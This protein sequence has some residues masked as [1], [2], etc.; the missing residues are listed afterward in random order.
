[1]AQLR[2]ASGGLAGALKDNEVKF[3]NRLAHKKPDSPLNSWH[4]I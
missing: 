3:I 4:A 2:E 1:M